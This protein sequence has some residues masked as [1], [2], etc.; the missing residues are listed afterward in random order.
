MRNH[1]RSKRLPILLSAAVIAVLAGCNNNSAKRPAAGTASNPA[2]APEVAEAP[3]QKPAPPAVKSK[4]KVAKVEK[5]RPALDPGVNPLDVFAV[6]PGETK[7][8]L[9]SVDGKP[10]S[11]NAF[12]GVLPPKGVDSTRFQPLE[13][14][15]PSAGPSKRQTSAA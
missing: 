11:D 9:A 6:V 10:V 1:N 5:P 2:A 3:R 12:T 4:P 7:W 13:T 15:K 8:Q 14:E